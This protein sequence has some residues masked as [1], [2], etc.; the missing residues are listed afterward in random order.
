MTRIQHRPQNA[1]AFTRASPALLLPLLLAAAGCSGSSAEDPFPYVTPLAPP[2]AG[3]EAVLSE[4]RVESD[5]PGIASRNV[6][7]LLPPGYADAANASRRYPVLYMHDGQN[8]LDHDPYGHG[9]WQV[10]IVSRDLVNAGRMAPALFV[11]VD[12]SGAREQEYVPGA[13]VAPG[14]TADG[15]LDFVERRVI[16]WVDARFRTLHEPSGRAIGGSSF[17]GIISLHAGRT[18]P[19]VFGSVM[20]MSPSLWRANATA[21]E[22]VKLPVR[23]Y[24]DSGTV[25]WGGGDDGFAATNALADL[26]VAKGWTLHV[27]LEHA[28]GEGHNH[29]EEY[30]RARLRPSTPTDAPGVWP[31]ALPF[32]FPPGP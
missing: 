22:I 31:G 26:L 16:P 5:V 21:D 17:G 32:L 20:A 30:W 2:L 12:N 9:G 14:P 29:S 18:R 25:D 13:G 23:V 19:G 15:Y 10:H 28:V 3:W 11:L 27:D 7:V 4:V 24:L 6:K 8:C 1:R